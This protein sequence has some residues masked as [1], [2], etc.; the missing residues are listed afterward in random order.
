MSVSHGASQPRLLSF[1]Q[2]SESIDVGSGN[3]AAQAVSSFNDGVAAIRFTNSVTTDNE[4]RIGPGKRLTGYPSSGGGDV[5]F[6]VTYSLNSTAGSGEASKWQL[7][8]CFS[9]PSDLVDDYTAVVVTVNHE[10]I[11]FDTNAY[12]D[13]TIPA[14]DVVVGAM[15]ALRLTRQ[16]ADAADTYV[17]GSGVFVHLA[18]LIYDG[19]GV[20]S[21]PA[22]S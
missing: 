2:I 7:D 8:Y 6:R 19:W 18:E 11:A 10:G 1:G 21:A 20:A 14:E 22:P 3:R 4:W 12:F 16:G 5:T 9:E 15:L 13:I 17:G